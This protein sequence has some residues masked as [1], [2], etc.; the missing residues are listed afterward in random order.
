MGYGAIQY[1]STEGL[2]VWELS[3]AV[4]QLTLLRS[5]WLCLSLP[6][7][8]APCGPSGEASHSHPGWCLQRTGWQLLA[9]TEIWIS[10]V[11]AALTTQKLLRLWNQHSPTPIPLLYLSW[12]EQILSTVYYSVK[13]MWDS[14]R[15]PT[16]HSARGRKDSQ[17]WKTV[18]KVKLSF[19]LEL[20]RGKG[21]LWIRR[22]RRGPL[23][24]L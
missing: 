15:F 3:E 2:L 1:G 21:I 4:G 12:G 22:E 13:Q 24:R 9:G 20:E 19:P 14:G 16:E 17:A 18:F 8:P 23:G 7:S 6:N 11:I 10:W 5:Y